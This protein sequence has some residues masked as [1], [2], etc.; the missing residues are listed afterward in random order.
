MSFREVKE[1]EATNE[2]IISKKLERIFKEP[3]MKVEDVILSVGDDEEMMEV[4]R[5]FSGVNNNPPDEKS[6]ED[7][8]REIQ[9]Y[10]EELAAIMAEMRVMREE[11]A[12][13][14]EE[15]LFTMMTELEETVARDQT[16]L[17]E[18]DKELAEAQET[19]QRL[20]VEVSRLRSD[21]NV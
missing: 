12:G 17:D 18:F 2:D 9:K 19:E 16:Q 3:N 15:M 21:K 8:R 13:D 11:Q 20:M 10:E 14:T 5:R 4:V 6:A 7:L 1:T